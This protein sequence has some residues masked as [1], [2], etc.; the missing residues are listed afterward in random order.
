MREYIFHGKCKRTGEWVDGNLILM[1]YLNL[2]GES[3]DVIAIQTYSNSYEVYEESVGQYTGFD[4]WMLD[5][6]SRDAKLYEGDIVEVWGNREIYG[7][8]WSQYD[9]KV[10]FRGVIVFEYGEWRIKFKNKYNEA[11]CKARGKEEYD[12][13][14]PWGDTLYRR[15]FNHLKDREKY[16][17]ERLE[18]RER[19]RR[20][21]TEDH[22]IYDDIIKIGTVFED[23]DLLEG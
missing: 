10:K 13:D 20:W 17:Q 5:D 1:H 11:I 7:S 18:S 19:C 8:N 6:V 23:A 16:R 4:E 15:Y 14:V 22:F 9:G 2:D 3:E 12:R 21:G